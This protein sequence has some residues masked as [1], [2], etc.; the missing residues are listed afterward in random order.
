M[1]VASSPRIVDQLH[2]CSA[3]FRTQPD[4]APDPG[5]P[6]SPPT[7][8]AFQKEE[9]HHRCARV[10]EVAQVAKKANS[11]DLPGMRRIRPARRRNGPHTWRRSRPSRRSVSRRCGVSSTGSG[12]T[13]PTAHSSPPENH[14]PANA[15]ISLPAPAAATRTRAP[16]GKKRRIASRSQ[17][18]RPELTNDSS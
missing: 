2:S 18:K 17:I 15:I 4:G 11:G 1:V 8:E 14:Y 13:Q 6:D 7:G 5:R 3:H 12:R 10:Q 9:D 16:V